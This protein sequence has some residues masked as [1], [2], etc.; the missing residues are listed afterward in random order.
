MV[1]VLLPLPTSRR[2]VPFFIAAVLA[3][4]WLA[5]TA[6]AAGDSWQ[7]DGLYQ[8]WIGD[9][10][11]TLPLES[12]YYTQ[13]C[14]WSGQPPQYHNWSQAKGQNQGGYPETVCLWANATN[15][16]VV[17][18]SGPY[19]ADEST[20]G[21]LYVQNYGYSNYWPLHGTF[22]QYNDEGVNQTNWAWFGA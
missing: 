12:P 10:C 4:G 14:P 2:A 7:F 6:R 13:V 18:P 20:N 16:Q 22:K 5:Q 21:V 3:T 1:R 19:C 8:T 15:G 9:P 17:P 11:I